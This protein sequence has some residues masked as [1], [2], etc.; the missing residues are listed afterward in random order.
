MKKMKISTL[1]ASASLACLL[2]AG[3]G[4]QTDQTEVSPATTQGSHINVDKIKAF[5]QNAVKPGMQDHYAA[6][7]EMY[8]NLTFEELEVFNKEISRLGLEKE[9][10]SAAGG[11]VSAAQQ[12][13]LEKHTANVEIYRSEVNKLAVKKYGVSFNKLTP[14]QLDGILTGIVAPSLGKEGAK[15]MA[16]SSASFPYVTSKTDNA[17]ANH[18]GW[19]R[20][21]TPS[22]PNDCDYEFSYSGF[23]SEIS[24]DNYLSQLLCSHWNYKIA[25]RS[26]FYPS[27]SITYLLFGNRGVQ[28][29][30]GTANYDVNMR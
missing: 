20:R 2:I 8:K 4:C 11:R 24:A 1:F 19:T 13:A 25:R 14:E 21:A 29:Y 16:C 28:L 27:A 15:I 5:A 12:A 26:V 18:T 3:I 22:A 10:Q 17:P 6:M 7:D 23:R 9:L 30:T